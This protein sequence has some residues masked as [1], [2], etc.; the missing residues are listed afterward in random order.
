HSKVTSQVDFTHYTDVSIRLAV[1][2]VNTLQNTEDQLDVAAL[3]A[4]LEPCG[5]HGPID[6]DDVVEVRAVRE[7]LRRVF[8]A[9]D[10]TRAAEELNRLLADAMAVPRISLHGDAG[11]HL[12]FEPPDASPA[13]WLAAT[14]AMGLAVVLCDYRLD[15]LGVC[16][17]STCADVYVDTSRNRSRR[18]CSD[19]CTTRENVA[20]YRRRQTS[21]GQDDVG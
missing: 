1:E 17:S 5:H 15:R 20:A 18:Y 7:R 16:E 12:H 6:Q 11:P 8:D 9:P 4:L 3:R 21:S 19:T 2:L 10:Q 13:R 14:T